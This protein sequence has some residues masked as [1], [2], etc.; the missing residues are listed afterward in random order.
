M[1]VKVVPVLISEEINPSEPSLFLKEPSSATPTTQSI[2]LDQEK[3]ALRIQYWYKQKI[4]I[5]WNVLANKLRIA[6]LS[7]FATVCVIVAYAFQAVAIL[8]WIKWKINV[9]EG[10]YYVQ[11]IF[12]IM[13]WFAIVPQRQGNRPPWQVLVGTILVPIMNSVNIMVLW[14]LLIV[15][16]NENVIIAFLVVFSIFQLITIPYCYHI[17][18][19]AMKYQ[20]KKNR[21]DL[22]NACFKIVLKG[23]GL[24]PYL[25]YT[26][27]DY[28]ALMASYQRIIPGLCRL[29]PGAFFDVDATTMA[30]IV[31]GVW[32][33]CT[34]GM[35]DVNIVAPDPVQNFDDMILTDN[36][37]GYYRTKADE[38]V[39]SSTLFAAFGL[40]FLTIVL[41]Y[42]RGRSIKDVIAFRITKVEL[43][44]CI[45]IF[46]ML[47]TVA[48]L[49]GLSIENMTIASFV[50]IIPRLVGALFWF[51]TLLMILSLILIWQQIQKM[52]KEKKIKKAAKLRLKKKN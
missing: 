41:V 52:K 9:A 19:T 27:I 29:V 51:A 10:F 17:F 3:A 15:D 20:Y 24:M 50:Y 33:N 13:S 2:E 22:L 34:L 4:S 39:G 8:C 48:M 12:I 25:F 16:I 5:K 7:K 31:T 35:F 40:Y 45:C 23:V 18:A 26:L 43:L 30:T 32:R 11:S 14:D 44:T 28:V 46:F 49:K 6:S 36:L 47:L 42:L 38:Q 21:N 37:V 1:S